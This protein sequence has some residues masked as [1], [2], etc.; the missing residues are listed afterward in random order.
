MTKSMS[1]YGDS[2][3]KLYLFSRLLILRTRGLV[4]ISNCT[5]KSPKIIILLNK[6][7]HTSNKNEN[8]P[9]N[10][11]SVSWLFLLGGG[12]HKQKKLMSP[13]VSVIDSRIT[14]NDWWRKE[15]V[16][17]IDIRLHRHLLYTTAMP[18]PRDS[19]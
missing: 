3:I 10:L 6:V 17:V 7:L 15:N 18:T 5:F 9:M 2:L 16:A 11:E 13:E 19:C 14:L 4:V 8:S 1:R 12:L